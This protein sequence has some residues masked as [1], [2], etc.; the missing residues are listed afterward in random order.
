MF[1]LEHRMRDQRRIPV[2]LVSPGRAVGYKILR[3]DR[4]GQ[5]KSLYQFGQFEVVY[6]PAGETVRPKG[7]LGL[8]AY[9]TEEAARRQL[10]I[11]DP[12]PGHLVIFE[13]EGQLM[14]FRPL[15]RSFYANEISSFY[16]GCFFVHLAPLED[17][18]ILFKI[19][20]LVRRID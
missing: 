15:Y 19:L 7:T 17:D 18:V 16:E 10:A 12:V 2:R 20:R 1:V 14:P 9:K 4:D 8:F 5:L 3:V 13:V 11:F 6:D